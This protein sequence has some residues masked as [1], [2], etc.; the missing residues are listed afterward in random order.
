MGRK[1]LVAALALAV[2]IAVGVAVAAA[3]RGSG[4]P[5]KPA[6]P[7]LTRGAGD[8]NANLMRRLQRDKRA[9]SQK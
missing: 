2:A 6:P 3:S 7:A 5:S 1:H 9:R 8:D 4:N